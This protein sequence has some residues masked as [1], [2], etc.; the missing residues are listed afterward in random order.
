MQNELL[1]DGSLINTQP[2]FD[3]LTITISPI[4]GMSDICPSKESIIKDKGY[5]KE[6]EIIWMEG[7]KDAKNWL[8]QNLDQGMVSFRAIRKV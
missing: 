2:V 7:Y 6:L 4:C 3:D 1:M 5:I 8:K